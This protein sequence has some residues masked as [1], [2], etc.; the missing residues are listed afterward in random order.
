MKK[1]IQNLNFFEGVS[2]NDLLEISKLTSTASWN[3]LREIVEKNLEDTVSKEVIRQMSIHEDNEDA[4][5]AI[6]EGKRYMRHIRS[7]LNSLEFLTGLDDKTIEKYNEGQK[8]SLELYKEEEELNK[9]LSILEELAS[10]TND[11]PQI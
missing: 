1:E 5:E 7:F 6:K 11:V 10:T 9:K 4:V 2:E 3:R 8:K